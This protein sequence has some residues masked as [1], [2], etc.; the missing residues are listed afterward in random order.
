[1]SSKPASNVGK[2]NKSKKLLVKK[3]TKLVKENNTN[4]IV[5]DKGKL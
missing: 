1:M 2:H 3:G 5:M 4:A